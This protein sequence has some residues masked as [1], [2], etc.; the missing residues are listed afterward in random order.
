MGRPVRWY[1][2]I[3]INIFYLGQTTLAQATGLI[4][5]LL[6]QDFVG[7]ELKGTLFG[8]L[9]L[10]SL[11]VAVLVQA[12]FGVISD[13]NNSRWGRRR[14]FIL[15]GSVLNLVFIAAIGLSLDME[16][17]SGYR[18]LFFAVLMLQLLRILP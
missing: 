16:N 13:R 1:D 9:R 10:W 14:P 5:P 2:Y 8:N 11:M 17:I 4:T 15:L 3:T 12:G 7:E 6:V 18:F